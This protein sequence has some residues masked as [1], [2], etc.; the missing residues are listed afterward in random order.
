[1]LKKI[2]SISFLILTTLFFIGCSKDAI[3]E[4]NSYN[5][6]GLKFEIPNNFNYQQSISSFT[7]YINNNG[8]ID[9]SVEGLMQRVG[10][11]PLFDQDLIVFSIDF[12]LVNEIQVNQ[13]IKIQN[14]NSV[15][16]RFPYSN[17][18]FSLITECALELEKQPS[19]TGFVK[20]TEITEGSI[21]GEFEFLNLKNVGGTNL[22]NYEP[23]PNYPGQQNYNI[24]KGSFK[25][26]R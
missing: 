4:L 20:I 15:G 26:L 6:L 7:E 11:N 25:A 9:Y 24:V 5:K 17:N 23:C 16:G 21:S 3:D 8:S 19:S 2:F 14:L 18:N 1:M 10:N 13:I 22:F 12:T